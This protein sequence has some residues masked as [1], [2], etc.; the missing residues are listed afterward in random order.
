[1]AAVVE[2]PG[3]RHSLAGMSRSSFA[4]RFGRAFGRSPL[5]FVLMVRLRHAAHLLATTA[6][7]VK[8]VADAVGYASRS[9]FS[10]A[11]KATYGADPSAYRAMNGAG[12]K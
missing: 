3:D 11:F 9:H 2:G 10:R 7:P 6:L 8:L 5:D 1:M 4:E 12:R